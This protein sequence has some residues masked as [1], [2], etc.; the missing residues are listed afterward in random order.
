MNHTAPINGS[1]ATAQRI[2]W[3]PFSLLWGTIALAGMSALEFVLRRKKQLRREEGLLWGI[4]SVSYWILAVVFT[5]KSAVSKA[6][7]DSARA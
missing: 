3:L 5:G 6:E 1:R 4:L 2:L 7:I